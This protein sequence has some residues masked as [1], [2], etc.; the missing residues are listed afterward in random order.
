MPAPG[1][2]REPWF[3]VSTRTATV[4]GWPNFTNL[5]RIDAERRVAIVPRAGE[6]AVHVDLRERH[7][8]IEVEIHFLAG[9]R[10]IERERLAIPAHTLPRQLAGVTPFIRIVRPGD[11]PIVRQPHRLPSGVVELL[12]LLPRAHRPC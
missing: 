6:F 4:F 1:Y 9:E 8:A 7:H 3:V 11:R 2:H 5:R 10:R 12:G